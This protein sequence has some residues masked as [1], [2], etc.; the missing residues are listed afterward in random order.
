MFSGVTAESS[1]F[2]RLIY[3][4]ESTCNYC[5]AR[6]ILFHQTFVNIKRLFRNKLVDLKFNAQHVQLY[7]IALFNTKIHN[8]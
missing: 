5:F 2:L 4:K 1:L 6:M 7:K 8:L 3:L